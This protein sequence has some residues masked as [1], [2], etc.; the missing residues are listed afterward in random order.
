MA[1]PPKEHLSIDSLERLL[2]K[3]EK[4]EEYEKCAEY[5]DRIAALRHKQ[6]QEKK[7]KLDENPPSPKD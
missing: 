1:F 4:D 5:R 2:K 7:Y 3:A 6:E